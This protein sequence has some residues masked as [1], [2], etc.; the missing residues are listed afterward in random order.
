MREKSVWSYCFNCRMSHYFVLLK[1]NTY[2][3]P[4]CEMI[5]EYPPTLAE[6]AERAEA[7][8]AAGKNE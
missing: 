4:N 6:V 1:N 8:I 7:F 2:R 5:R 3:C